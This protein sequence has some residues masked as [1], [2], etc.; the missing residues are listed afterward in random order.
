MSSKNFTQHNY[1]QRGESIDNLI[2]EYKE[3]LL[4]EGKSKNTV[5]NYGLSIEE[6]LRWY[7]ETYSLEFVKLFRANVTEY[8][9][10]LLNVKKHRGKNLNGKTVNS[11]L[12]GIRSLNLFLVEIG[13]QEEMVIDHNDFIKIQPNYYNPSTID[14]KQVEEFRQKILLSED[15]RL[16]A[17]VTLLAYTGL[18]IS[19]A[20]M[21]KLV[22]VNLESKE[23][24][25]RNG[26][27]Q[28]QR[29]LYINSRVVEAIRD[30]L[31]TRKVESEY[32]FASRNGKRIDRTTINKY[33][34][35]YSDII[36]PHTLRH[37]FCSLALESGFGIHEVGQIVGHS[38]VRTTQI[39][40]NPS[41]KKIKSKMEEL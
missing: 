38:D 11:K 3:Y 4:K 8:K 40:L 14:K 19:E 29:L 41:T 12:S 21:L 30:Y 16:F 27:G 32:L 10:Y 15:K 34:N 31:R 33:F 5:Y 39:Y 6:Y 2:K 18:R 7:D 17:I 23:L 24:I 13:I 22:D 1:T 20:L 37:F 25:V 36:T 9:S 28:K 35:N 26:K